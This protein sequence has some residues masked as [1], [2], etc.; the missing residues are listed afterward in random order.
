V[1]GLLAW[2]N[3][4]GY[5]W[6]RV[7]FSAW[8][9]FHTLVLFYDIANLSASAPVWTVIAGVVFWLVE[10]AAVAL[11]VSR[12]S[13]SFYRRRLPSPSSAL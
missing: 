10:L 5:N 1:F 12:Q 11:I 3:G 4:R 2:A 9:A 13:S 8:F 7:L 6:A